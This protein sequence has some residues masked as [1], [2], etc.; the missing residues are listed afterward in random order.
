[1]TTRR[2]M[3][4]NPSANSGAKVEL[5]AMNSD[6]KWIL[7]SRSLNLKPVIFGPQ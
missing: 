3:P 7:A 1:M 2:G 4:S 5:N 6:Q